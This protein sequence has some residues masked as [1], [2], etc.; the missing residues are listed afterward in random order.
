MA[1][2]IYES[3]TAATMSVQLAAARRRIALLE[4]ENERLRRELRLLSPTPDEL[5]ALAGQSLTTS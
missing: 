5:L 3:A 1:K 4:A 2:A